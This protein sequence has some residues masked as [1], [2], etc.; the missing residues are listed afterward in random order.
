[1]VRVNGKFAVIR[2][3]TSKFQAGFIDAVVVAAAGGDQTG[4][5]C[6][7]KEKFPFLPAITGVA[8]LQPFDAAVQQMGKKGL[9]FFA[10]QPLFPLAAQRVRPDREAPGG[11]DGVNGGLRLDP[12]PARGVLLQVAPDRLVQI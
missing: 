8:A 2:A 1:M 12:V 10:C 6:P 11:Q 7:G 3:E 4:G 9:E 5:G